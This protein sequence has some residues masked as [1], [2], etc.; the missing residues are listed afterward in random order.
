[1][2]IDAEV[3]DAD[4]ERVDDEVKKTEGDEELNQLTDGDE[5]QQD[6]T[7]RPTAAADADKGVFCS[8]I[9]F[10]CNGSLKTSCISF[11]SIA[12]TYYGQ[13]DILFFITLRAK[14]SGAAY[15][16]RSCLC[17]TGGRAVAVTTITRNCVH[18]SS[19]NWVCRCR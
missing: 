13:K 4:V 1:M 19:P 10:D 8:L 5:L 14:L 3:A 17:V 15:C 18:R 9:T 12:N 16:Y 2:T 11:A 7:D 6:D